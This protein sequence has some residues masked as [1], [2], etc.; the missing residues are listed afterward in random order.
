MGPT[1]IS[2]QVGTSSYLQLRLHNVEPRNRLGNGVLDLNPW[3]NFNE[4]KLV[5]LNEKL[6]RPGIFVVHCG[7]KVSRCR[8][9]PVAQGLWQSDCGGNFDHLLVPPLD[10]TITFKQVNEVSVLSPTTCTS[11][12]LACCR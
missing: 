11:T 10:R 8:A 7:H 2:E 6:D 5:P 12:C 3:V 1:D 4:V 9:Y